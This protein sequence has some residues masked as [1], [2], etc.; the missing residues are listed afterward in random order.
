MIVPFQPSMQVCFVASVSFLLDLYCKN[1]TSSLRVIRSDLQWR[2]NVCDGVS[3]YRRLDCLRNCWCRRI[4]KKTPKLCI[5]GLCEGN[6]PVTDGFPSQR[7]SYAE[8]FPF[9]DVNMNSVTWYW[10]VLYP[11]SGTF[12]YPAIDRQHG[13]LV[14]LNYWR[15]SP[16]T[17]HIHPTFSLSHFRSFSADTCRNDNV[18]IM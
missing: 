2:H 7:A 15:T 5:T 17:K 8:M 4:S 14:L 3:N 16:G 9:N 13:Y 12:M 18:I 10:G 1:Q 6:P 11:Q